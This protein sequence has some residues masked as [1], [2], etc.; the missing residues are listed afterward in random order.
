MGPAEITQN[1]EMTKPLRLQ[2]SAASESKHRFWRDSRKR[3]TCGGCALYFRT[4]GLRLRPSSR[5]PQ[6]FWQAKGRKRATET[7]SEPAV[8]MHGWQAQ[9]TLVHVGNLRCWPTSTGL[10]QKGVASGQGSTSADE[11]KLWRFFQVFIGRKAPLGGLNFLV[12]PRGSSHRQDGS[13]SWPPRK[14]PQAAPRRRPS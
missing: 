5:C 10:K 3:G 4:V 8:R 7:S 11:V 12:R 13:W 9:R 6:Y 2:V 14:M 1:L